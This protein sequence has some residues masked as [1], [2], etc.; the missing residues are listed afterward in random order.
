[1]SSDKKAMLKHH[2]ATKKFSASHLPY[3][4]N[5]YRK[6]E[7]KSIYGMCHSPLGKALMGR[8]DSLQSTYSI[9]LN[10]FLINCL[11]QLRHILHLQLIVNI[12]AVGFNSKLA[13]KQLLRHFAVAL[14]LEYQFNDLLF[15]AA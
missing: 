2:L 13:N 5:W 11:Y 8:Q 1:M 6:T 15:A 9:Q 14:A 3:S 10:P 4:V 12:L 7:V